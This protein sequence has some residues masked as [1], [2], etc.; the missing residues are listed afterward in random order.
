MLG[1]IVL[2]C[3]GI[4]K[5]R[6]TYTSSTQPQNCKRYIDCSVFCCSRMSSCAR[7][8]YDRSWTQYDLLTQNF[9][10]YCET[11]IR[12]YISLKDMIQWHLAIRDRIGVSLKWLMPKCKHTKGYQGSDFNLHG[13]YTA[14]STKQERIAV[15]WERKLQNVED[16]TWKHTK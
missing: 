6:D 16:G 13:V 12:S 5:P 1:N 3:Q 2:E 15:L 8:G 10:K 4:W 11:T 9:P 14:E 7:Q